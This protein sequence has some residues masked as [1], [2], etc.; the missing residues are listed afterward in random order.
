MAR[1]SSADEE[2]ADMTEC[3]ICTEVFTDPRILPCHHTFCLKCLLHYGQDRQP[4]DQM[5]CPL[6]REQFIIPRG[7]LSEMKKDFKMETWLHVRKRPAGKAMCEEHKGEEIRMFCQECSIAMCVTCFVKSHNTH[8]CSDIKEVSDILGDTQKVSELRKITEDVLER[9]EKEK[10]D[11]IEHLAGIEYEINTAADKS[12]AA[13]QRDREKLLSEVKSIKLKRV[14]QVE[15]VKQEV[16]Q[17]KA[18]LESFKRDRET[19]LSSGTAAGDVTKSLHDRAEQL[20]KF[21]VIG[22]VHSSLPP[23]NV[24]FTSSTLL[25][26]DD[27]NL[28]GTV[29][30]EGQLQSFFLTQMSF[31]M[32]P[33][34]GENGTACLLAFYLYSMSQNSQCFSA[35][36][37]VISQSRPTYFL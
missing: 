37:S 22:H 13:I 18:G 31:G 19:L 33:G 3:S 14:K 26:R 36:F 24:T 17:Y 23:V 7:G 29:T 12:I 20:M 27:R 15:T 10:N 16:E 9:L 4:G 1:K 28:V 25:D 11:V 35:T 2:L 32:R 6:C 5:N 21:D 30:E 34:R 8:R